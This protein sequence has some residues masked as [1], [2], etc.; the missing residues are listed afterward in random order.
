MTPHQQIIQTFIRHVPEMV[1]PLKQRLN[2][3][4]QLSHQ[5]LYALSR[6]IEWA[7]RLDRRFSHAFA[8]GAM[9]LFDQ[10]E[11][12]QFYAQK[13]RAYGQYGVTQGLAIA[14]CLHRVLIHCTK[15]MLLIFLQ[16][17]ES[18]RRSGPHTL[19]EPFNMFCQL[20]D[21]PDPLCANL[22]L[23]LLHQA[24]SQPMNFQD[25][26]MLAQIIPDCCGNMHKD[27]RA[28]QIKQFK[29]VVCFYP[30]W[31]D[32]YAKGLQEGLNILSESALNRFI[33]EAITRY[34]TSPERGVSF[35]TIHSELAQE[36]YRELQ[37][38]VALSQIIQPL[39]N[40][41]Q[42]RT[43]LP[44]QIRP[45]SD[46]A[47]EDFSPMSVC[48]DGKTIFLP[49]EM[50]VFDSKR[51]N[52]RIYKCLIRLEAG[53]CEYDTF[54]FD[55]EKVLK[56]IEKPELARHQDLITPDPDYFFSL[57]QHPALAEDLFNIIE[58]G[59]I[60]LCLSHDYPGMIRHAL[61]LIQKETIR[62]IRL[63][64]KSTPILYLYARI[65]LNMSKK[66]CRFVYD[67]LDDLIHTILHDLSHDVPV[68][69]SASLVYQVFPLLHGWYKQAAIDYTRL[70][71]PFGRKINLKLFYQSCQSYDIRAKIIRQKLK[72]LDIPIYQSD[73]RNRLSEKNGVITIRD[74]RRM[75]KAH[76]GLQ[77]DMDDMDLN[78]LFEMQDHAASDN[79]L[80]DKDPSF[81][82]KEWDCDLCD[83]LP[84]HTR[85]YCRTM[86]SG[87]KGLYFYQLT[88]K[89]YSGLLKRIRRSFEFL[90]PQ[91]I[92][93]LRQ[94]CEGDDFDYRALI[95]YA[96][97]RKIKQTPSDRLYI[98]HIKQQRDVSVFLLVDLSRSTGFRIPQSHQR[99]LEVEKEAIVL[100]CEALQQS[101]DRFAIAAFS[102]LGRKCVEFFQVKSFDSPHS[103][104]IK[105]RISALS[106]CRST[107]MGAAI[108]HSTVQLLQTSSKVRLLIMLSDGLPNDLDY[109]NQY[110]IDDTRM[111]IREARA[112][113]IHV[114]GITVNVQNTNALDILY[115]QGRHTLIQDVKELPD[116]LPVIYRHLT[117]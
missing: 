4:Y 117:G 71:P 45:V 15:K 39:V 76:T 87:T 56:R 31:A 95:D 60:R 33:S 55:L 17:I 67:D 96:V 6:H 40:Y 105:R 28:Y 113:N 29:Q 99:I 35:L 91:G 23:N 79:T 48:T 107:R 97:D 2:L 61:P 46:L 59:R 94:W 9:E 18:M 64:S 32:A 83:Y 12:Y 1:E 68:E 3:P 84:A 106:P 19:T 109:K 13:V 34:K 5:D 58:Q 86:D 10:P 82:Y 92:V 25:S 65:A 70:N 78:Q 51:D 20:F 74:I 102:G 7:D 110:A 114:H 37:S 80:S 21:E 88:L 103:D 43:G 111:A 81:A 14:R 72:N 90:K 73:I 89:R 101:G 93:V 57:F 44:L 116:K 85:I 47:H 26:Q 98:K 49:D 42:A 112:L 115:G 11:E 63:A 52:V 36:K 41:V 75:F 50:G 66:Q 104:Q 53:L 30:K 108:R 22:Y 54:Q 77:L 69:H 27:R 8:T 16:T 62:M 24:F 38:V 100:F